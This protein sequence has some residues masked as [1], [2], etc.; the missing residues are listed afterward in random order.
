VI[1]ISTKFQPVGNFLLVVR[2]ESWM[3][4]NFSS[5]ILPLVAVFTCDSRML[6]LS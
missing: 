5:K 1:V 6:S 4:S 2:V 3:L